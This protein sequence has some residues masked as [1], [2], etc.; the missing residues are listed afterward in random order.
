MAIR[1]GFSGVARAT[2]MRQRTELES[3]FYARH[4]RHL[5][6]ICGGYGM[7]LSRMKPQF[8]ITWHLRL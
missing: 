1:R 5:C 2:Q 8:D 7:F 6:G 4:V 3:V